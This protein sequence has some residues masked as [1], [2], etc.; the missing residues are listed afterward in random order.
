M[1]MAPSTMRQSATAKPR[2]F[3]I[4]NRVI[5]IIRHFAD[6]QTGPPA[7]SRLFP[8]DFFDHDVAQRLGAQSGGFHGVDQGGAQSALF[9]GVQPGDGRTAGRG[10]HIFKL[11]WV[12]ACFQQHL[13]GTQN[14]LR[15]KLAGILRAARC[16][17]APGGPVL[18]AAQVKLRRMVRKAVKDR[19]GDATLTAS[20][21]IEFARSL[22]RS[23]DRA[24]LLTSGNI[25]A[26]L[27]TLLDGNLS[28]DALRTS[29]RG[30]DVL[31]FWLHADSPLWVHDV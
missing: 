25:A 3:C 13:G 19:V 27:S 12:E 24:G 6:W 26:A 28:L 8:V 17:L 21:L 30:L 29:P 23:A 10:H 31:R 22:Q 15:G 4:W 16:E 18:P 9:E 11:A 7:V 20:T 1:N 14:G 2:V 5:G